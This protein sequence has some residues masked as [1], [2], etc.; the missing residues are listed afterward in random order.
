MSS[1]GQATPS[2][3]F[4]LIV[5]VLAEYA[6]LTGIDL[7]KNPFAEKI[8]QSNSPEAILDLL[9]ERENAFKEYRDGNR[10][11]INCLSPAVKV[12]QAFSGI[13]GEA[14]CLVNVA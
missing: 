2:H 9:Q 10:R 7:T 6:K 11:L 12:V 8:E 13:L 3:N 5:N 4:Q 14:V 1:T